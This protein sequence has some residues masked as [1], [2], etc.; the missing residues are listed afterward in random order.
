MAAFRV[1]WLQGAQNRESWKVLE[2]AFKQQWE[3]VG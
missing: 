2:E 3:T 1:N